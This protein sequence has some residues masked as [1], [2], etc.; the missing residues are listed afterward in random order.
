MWEAVAAD[1]GMAMVVILN[2][3][4]VLAG[5]EEETRTK[6]QN[7]GGALLAATPKQT[8]SAPLPV[9]TAERGEATAA[10]VSKPAETAAVPP[11]TPVSAQ[12]QTPPASGS[13]MAVP[14]LEGSKPEEAKGC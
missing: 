6:E 1:V 9:E 2:G 10:E 8:A 12:A 14:P 5:T 3:M 13:P 7:D 11:Q 4:A